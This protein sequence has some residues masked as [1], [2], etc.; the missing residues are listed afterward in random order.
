MI[1]ESFEAWESKADEKP[2]R[3]VKFGDSVK[4]V[5]FFK[6]YFDAQSVPSVISMSPSPSTSKQ[7]FELPISYDSDVEMIEEHVDY[8]YLRDTSYEYDKDRINSCENDEDHARSKIPEVQASILN[9]RGED[10]VNLA[11]LNDEDHS[12]RGEDHVNL[13]HLNDEDHSARGEDHVNLAQLNDEDHSALCCDEDRNIDNVE[14]NKVLFHI[15]P[16]RVEKEKTHMCDI[17]GGLYGLHHSLATHLKEKHQRILCSKCNVHFSIDDITSH[18]HDVHNNMQFSILVC[19]ICGLKSS[20]RG[21]FSRHITKHV[22]Q[23]TYTCKFCK[24]PFKTFYEKKVH[25]LSCKI[26]VPCKFKECKTVCH[27]MANYHAHLRYHKCILCKVEFPLH[28][29]ARMH[30]G[31]HLNKPCDLHDSLHDSGPRKTFRTF[32]ILYSFR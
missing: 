17:C 24:T 20:F 15:I 23:R 26:Q 9:A 19:D 21:S 10:H 8:D 25:Q 27:S 11:H 31:T 3:Y 6:D 14:D 18:M 16:D 5:D 2:K 29:E 4:L 32:K 28:R 30:E 1:Q 13:A 22:I 12:A 7:S